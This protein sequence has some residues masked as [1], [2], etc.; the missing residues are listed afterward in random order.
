MT[1]GEP[2]PT[3][4]G[5]GHAHG[6]Q[7]KEVWTDKMIERSKEVAKLI[8]VKVIKQLIDVVMESFQALHKKLSPH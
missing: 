4:P 2:T 7:I 3:D 8:P 5:H 6:D 1:P